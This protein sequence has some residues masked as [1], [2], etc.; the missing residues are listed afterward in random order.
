[1]HS[2]YKDRGIIKWAAFDAL[3]GFNSMLGEMR[4]RLRKIKKPILSEDDF[5]IFNRKMNQALSENLDISIT[6]Y[7]KGYFK[8]TFGKIKKVDYINKLVILDTLEKIQALDII[9]IENI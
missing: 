9:N 4:H 7:E 6:Y 5:D 8:L 2:V 3:A 1:M